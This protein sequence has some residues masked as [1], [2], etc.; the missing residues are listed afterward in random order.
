MVE[1]KTIANKRS[2]KCGY[3]SSLKDLKSLYTFTDKSLQEVLA[4]S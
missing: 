3:A 1:I 2:S 4:D